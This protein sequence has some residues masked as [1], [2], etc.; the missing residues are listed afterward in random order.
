MHDATEC[1]IWGALFEM[2]RAA[3]VGIAV[4]KRKI[5][6]QDI[7]LRICDLFGIE[8]FKTIS[9]GTLVAAVEPRSADTALG[10]LASAGIAAS[11]VGEL[12]PASSGVVVTDETGTRELEHPR[13]DPFWGTFEEYLAKQAARGAAPRAR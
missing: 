3:G 7:V 11:V 4:D 1:G 2:A 5:V 6:T 12:T 9:E 10:A 8:P 13:T